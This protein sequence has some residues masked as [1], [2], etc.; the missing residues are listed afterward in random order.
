MWNVIEEDTADGNHPQIIL[1]ATL[2]RL[3]HTITST[4]V[5]Q[6]NEGIEAWS[7]ILQ[8]SQSIEVVYALLKSLDMA[9]EHCAVG[10]NT[11]IM[12]RTMHRQPLLGTT[13]I[14]TYLLT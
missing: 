4:V 1:H 14:G 10:S 8:L 6:W 5:L 9:I 7:L 13:L 11:H 3:R 12:R 2:S